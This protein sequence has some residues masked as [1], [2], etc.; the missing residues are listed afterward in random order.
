MKEKTLIC[1]S[2]VVRNPM[3]QYATKF[4]VIVFAMG[5]SSNGIVFKVAVHF[6]NAISVLFF[7]GVQTIKR[8]HDPVKKSNIRMTQKKKK[9][10]TK[11]KTKKK[12]IK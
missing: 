2:Y 10:K 8:P 6:A 1:A 5:V 12:T 7:I 11:K 3:L 9:T 4:V